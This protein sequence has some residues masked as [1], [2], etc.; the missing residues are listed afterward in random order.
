MDCG[1]SA[2]CRY[3]YKFS[4]EYTAQNIQLRMFSQNLQ[5]RMFS[6]NMQSESTAR[7]IAPYLP[8]LDVL[9]GGATVAV[10]SQTGGHSCRCAAR[11]RHKEQR[12]ARCLIPASITGRVACKFAV[13]PT[14]YRQNVQTEYTAENIQSEYSSLPFASAS[15]V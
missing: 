14:I 5:L 4:S 9:G 3:R 11:W 13:L 8:R 7:N 6:Q 10:C 2:S 12:L 1:F 15:M